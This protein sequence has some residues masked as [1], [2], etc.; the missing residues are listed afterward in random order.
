[1]QAIYHQEIDLRTSRMVS[2]VIPLLQQVLR[3]EVAWLLRGL[4]SGMK[5][6]PVMWG[7]CHKA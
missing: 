3:G 6:Y 4:M 2:E 5:S 1:M 7:L